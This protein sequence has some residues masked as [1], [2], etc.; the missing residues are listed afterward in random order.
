MQ[1]LGAVQE[2]V[3][4]EE[5]VAE[6]RSFTDLSR[7]KPKFGEQHQQ[8]LIKTI[9]SPHEE[10]VAKPLRRATTKVNGPGVRQED[11]SGMDKTWSA[12][13][14]QMAGNPDRTIPGPT[15]TTAV[16]AKTGKIVERNPLQSGTAK[17]PTLPFTSARLISGKQLPR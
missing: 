8:L 12:K 7:Q 11:G 4:L 5:Q 17:N 3:A 9:S 6:D 2:T 14:F 13:A 10:T 16:G 15:T 1:Y